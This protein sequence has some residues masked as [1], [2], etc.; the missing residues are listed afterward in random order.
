MNAILKVAVV[1]VALISGAVGAQAGD[2][3]EDGAASGQFVTT[4]GILSNR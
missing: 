1:A 4:G 2:I 3:L